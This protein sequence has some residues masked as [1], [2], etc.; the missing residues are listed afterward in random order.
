MAL[1]FI[2]DVAMLLAIVSAVASPTVSPVFLLSFH[3]LLLL[4]FQRCWHYRKEGPH[5]EPAFQSTTDLLI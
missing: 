1:P 2:E 5:Q 4:S 3:R